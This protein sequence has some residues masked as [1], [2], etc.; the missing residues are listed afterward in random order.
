MANNTDDMCTSHVAAKALADALLQTP[1]T[2]QSDAEKAI[3]ASRKA[4]LAEWGRVT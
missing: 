1:V 2:G 4:V 3:E